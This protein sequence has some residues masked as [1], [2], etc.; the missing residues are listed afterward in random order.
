MSSKETIVEKVR[1]L[2]ALADGNQNENERKVAM[3]FAMDL[4]AKHNLDMV[5]VTDEKLEIKIEEIA[6]DFK[7][8][9]WIRTVLQ[10]ACELYYTEFFISSSWDW[11]LDKQIR[12]PVFVG[13]AENIAVTVDM[14]AWLINSIRKESNLAFKDNF[15]RRSFRLGAASRV[16]R[17]TREMKAAEEVAASSSGGS[18]LMVLRN[19]LELANE[20][21]LESLNLQKFAS[22]RSYL[23]KTA[24]DVGVEYGDQLRLN[25]S[26]GNVRR[27]TYAG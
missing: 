7:L 25:Q 17:R 15:N 14:A 23:N 20:Q 19:Q 18:S 12:F 1:K 27:L 9:P 10:A 24:Y 11:L 13:T 8:D 3:Q 16:L 21:Y 4:L 22:R 5:Q 6:A 26:A 2:L